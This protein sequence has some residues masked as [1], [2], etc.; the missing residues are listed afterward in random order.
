MHFLCLLSN[1]D[2]IL[3]GHPQNILNDHEFYDF[4]TVKFTLRE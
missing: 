1:L 4:D 3:N 2:E